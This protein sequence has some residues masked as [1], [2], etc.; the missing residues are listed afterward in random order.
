MTASTLRTLAILAAMAGGALFPSAHVL[1]WLVRWLVMV[2]LFSVALQV[3]LSRRVLHRSHWLLLVA[4]IVVALVSFAI[5]RLVGDRDLALAAFFTAIAPTATAAPVVT[6]FLR[7]R[8]EYVLSAFLLTNLGI[9]AVMPVLLALVLT[10]PTPSVVGEVGSNI[11]LVVF[12]PLAAGWLLRRIYPPAALWPR[13]WNNVTFGAWT[14]TL[15]LVSANISAFVLAQP[16]RPLAQLV[17]IGCASLLIC[18]VNFGVG[19]LVGG[20]Q[21]GKEASQSLG[22]KNTTL[23]LFLAL[24]YA[25]PLVALGPAFYV[26]WHNLWNSWQLHRAARLTVPGAQGQD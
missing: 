20:A 10:R 24:T 22:Q 5:A 15:F 6:S 18:V 2:L 4:N 13:R 23:T 26:L 3:Q 12:L 25:N 8:V 9:A 7:G 11:A 16:T 19:H 14:A 1:S 21:Y 17:A